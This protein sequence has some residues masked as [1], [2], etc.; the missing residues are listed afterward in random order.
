M[1]LK[2]CLADT[3]GGLI[4]GAEQW[5]VKSERHLRSSKQKEKKTNR[6]EQPSSRFPAVA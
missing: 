5:S 1:M 4:G 2:G 3:D 6:K